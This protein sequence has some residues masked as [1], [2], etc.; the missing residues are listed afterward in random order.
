MAKCKNKSFLKYQEYQTLN[1]ILKSV[2][3]YFN[4]NYCLGYIRVIHRLPLIGCIYYL[5]QNKIPI[6]V[7]ENQFTG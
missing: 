7:L 5:I 2:E 1:H 6:I 4:L 3:V